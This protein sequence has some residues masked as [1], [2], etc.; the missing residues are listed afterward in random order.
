MK[1]LVCVRM[2]VQNSN[3]SGA[4]ELYRENMEA[5]NE[6]NH[7]S[8]QMKMPGY[9]RNIILDEDGLPNILELHRMDDDVQHTKKG[10]GGHHELHENHVH[11]H[12]HT[13]DPSANVFFTMDNLRVGTKLAVYFRDRTRSSSSPFLP[14]KEADSIPFSLDEFPSLLDHF[15]F[16]KGS[17]QAKA[18]EGTL[19]QC[20]IKPIQGETKFCATSLESM[21]EFTRGIL[22]VGTQVG[23]LV[24]VHQ[25]KPSAFLQN[26][27]ILKIPNEIRFLKMVACHTMPY[28]YVVFYCHSQETQNKIFRVSLRG[29]DGDR[30]EAIAVCHMDTSHW[31]REHMSFLVLRINPGT[32]PVCHFFQSDNLIWVTEKK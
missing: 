21:L 4:R 18:M 11:A 24:T 14:K 9:K 13:M 5:L 29:D 27:T 1:F 31:P 15:S 25:N 10:D 19:R 2:W 20:N 3:E 17:P 30:V 8:K 23:V 28:P 16:S 26:Y 7:E 32:I 22:G 12:M 6:Q